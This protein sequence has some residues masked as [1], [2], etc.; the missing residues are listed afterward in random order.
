[1]RERPLVLIIDDDV[2]Y[3]RINRRLLERHGYD[4]V[5]AAVGFEGV[6][7]ARDHHPDAIILD[8]MMES[9]TAGAAVAQQLSEDE[10]LK[11]I[12]IILITAARTVKPWWGDKLSP[13]E[14]WLPVSK[15]MDK[16]VNPEQLLAELDELLHGGPPT[17][18]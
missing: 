17:A 13:N 1:M 4:V 12:P 6:E 18:S 5:T 14:D 9:N 7:Q 16:P 11:D 15:V 10:K 3:V 8:F 2:D